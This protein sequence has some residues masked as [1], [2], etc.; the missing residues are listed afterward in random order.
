MSQKEIEMSNL[1]TTDAKTAPTPD[2]LELSATLKK[3]SRPGA[4]ANALYD[5][6]RS[7]GYTLEEIDSIGGE[8]KELAEDLP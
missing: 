5:L 1:S 6:L 7:S 3:R 2:F 4:V 8:L